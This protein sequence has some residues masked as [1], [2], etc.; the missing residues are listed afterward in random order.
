[1]DKKFPHLGVECVLSFEHDDE[2]KPSVTSAVVKCNGVEFKRATVKK[3]F[4]DKCDKSKAEHFAFT[5]LLIICS[6]SLSKALY[7][8]WAHS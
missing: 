3:H 4:K 1:M 6:E 7:D 2:S 5:K 8:S